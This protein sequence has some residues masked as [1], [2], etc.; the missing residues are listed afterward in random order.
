M[1][2]VLLE[3]L[4]A[5]LGFNVF[6]LNIN[7][8]AVE[9]ISACSCRCPHGRETE[10]VPGRRQEDGRIDANMSSGEQLQVLA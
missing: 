7:F 6:S 4:E 9:F 1:G 8:I 3:S 5:A 10:G 2:D